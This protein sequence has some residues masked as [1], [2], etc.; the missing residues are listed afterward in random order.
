MDDDST[1]TSAFATSVASC[2]GLLP[3]LSGQP[4]KHERQ[5]DHDSLR[6]GAGVSSPS[7][8]AAAASKT[9]AQQGEFLTDLVAQL[10]PFIR[11]AASQR[12]RAAVEP[13][14]T[15]LPTPLNTL[16]FVRS[17]VGHV[18]IRLD[19]VVVHERDDEHASLQFD[20]D[21]AWDGASDIQLMS[22]PITSVRWVYRPSRS[23]GDCRSSCNPSRPN[24]PLSKP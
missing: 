22:R 24:Y 15:A 7:S 5:A 6:N 1:I 18:P 17:D 3:L 11:I 10:W 20:V 13:R 9:N 21:V 4:G 12:I 8:S 2:F 23:W 16:R 19:D 14:L